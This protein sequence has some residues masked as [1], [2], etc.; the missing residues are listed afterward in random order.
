MF[1]GIT[2]MRQ[3]L[4]NLFEGLLL[5]KNIQ[6]KTYYL[7]CCFI[8]LIL[9]GIMTWLAESAW[10]AAWAYTALIILIKEL[11]KKLINESQTPDLSDGIY[12]SL[13][14]AISGWPFLI[15]TARFFKNSYI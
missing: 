1:P 14:K 5:N 2:K 10:C 8:A 13:Y 11:G 7:I 3:L 4:V 12:Y 15:L 6:M 9:F